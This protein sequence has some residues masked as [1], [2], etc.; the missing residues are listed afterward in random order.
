MWLLNTTTYRHHFEVSPANVLYATLSHVWDHKGEDSFQ[1]IQTIHAAARA[2]FATTPTDDD[3]ELLAI[4]RIQLST[5]V[6]RCCDYARAKGLPYVWIDTCCINKTSSAELSEAINSMFDWYSFAEVCYVFLAD[7]PSSEDPW[8]R[9]SAFRRSR[10]FGRG[11]TLQELIVPPHNIFLSRDWRMLGTKASLADVVKEV[12]GIDPDILLHSRPLHAVS[13]AQRM[14]WASQRET[15]RLED[16]AYCLMGIFGVRLSIIYGE[17]RQAFIRLQEEILRRVPDQTLFLWGSLSTLSVGPA[18]QGDLPAVTRIQ[19]DRLKASKS[20]Y[21]LATCPTDFSKLAAEFAPLPLD[22]FTHIVGLPI[23]GPP[24]YVLTSYGMRATLPV[25]AIHFP[26]SNVE[27]HLA[28]LACRDRQG[29]LV[30]LILS[31]ILPSWM[32]LTGGYTFL[33]RPSHPISQEVSDIQSQ[34]RER[35]RQNDKQAASLEQE[36]DSLRQVLRANSAHSTRHRVSHCVKVNAAR[37]APQYPRIALIDPAFFKLN[38]ASGS[39]PHTIALRDICIPHQRLH[40][41]SE[42]SMLFR[43]PEETSKLSR[44]DR[45]GF[46]L[47][48][49]TLAHLDS[50]RVTVDVT[51]E[52]GETAPVYFP[53]SRPR[54]HCPNHLLQLHHSTTTIEV[55][56]YN[57]SASGPNQSVHVVVSERGVPLQTQSPGKGHASRH[58]RRR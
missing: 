21:L 3:P 16:E 20:A 2:T 10:W 45:I 17:G 47:P 7:V 13:V 40:T 12:T 35:A 22:T 25:L 15:T 6:V 30:A 24:Q 32:H 37:H 53:L 26:E 52:G 33:P 57:C 49:W 34:L 39:H 1:D 5:K 44:P 46:V 19:E 18:G 41:Q 31:Q 56:V 51:I 43:C 4:L 28:L 14:S 8:G 58:R 11:W 42:L 29:R 55:A 27:V 36:L 38:D 54:P 23:P 9:L 50:H 48:P